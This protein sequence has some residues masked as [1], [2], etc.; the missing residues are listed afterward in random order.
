MRLANNGQ[1]DEG[2]MLMGPQ[3][4]PSSPL[5]RYELPLMLCSCWFRRRSKVDVVVCVDDVMSIAVVRS[6]V[7]VVVCEGVV[8]FVVV[9]GDGNGSGGPRSFSHALVHAPCLP[10]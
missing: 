2:K 6:A 3:P 8:V 4:A 5:A 10:G 1:S 9:E 7:D